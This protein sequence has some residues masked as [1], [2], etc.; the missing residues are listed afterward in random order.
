MQFHV[1]NHQLA[2]HMK[3]TIEQQQNG[4]LQTGVSTNRRFSLRNGILLVAGAIGL[5]AAGSGQAQPVF[6][7]P[8]YEPF[9]SDAAPYSFNSAYNN[10][11][12]INNEELG[13][14]ATDGSANGSGYVWTF[15][16][17]IS[18]SCSRILIT[19]GVSG[20]EYPGL[21][22]V[23]ATYQ[24]GLLSMYI[25]DTGSTKDRAV[26]L[27]IPTNN[28]NAPFPIYASCL[29][30]IQ[31]NKYTSSSPFAFF[32]LSAN[33]APNTSV[34]HNGA[35]AYVSY[36]GVN[37]NF[38]LQISKNSTTADTHLTSA[39]TTSN[40]YLLVLRYNY[41]AG[42]N[43][44]DSVDLWVDPIALG[45][46]VTV[47][48][49]TISTTNN[50]NLATNFFGAV[51][52]FEA[53]NPCIVY[54]DEIRVAT[55]WGGVTPTNA[56]PGNIY[57][58]TGG[59]AGCGSTSFDVGLSGSDT[60]VTYWLYTNGVPTGISANGTTGQTIDFGPQTTTALYTVAGSNNT[61]FNQGWMNGSASV[62]VLAAPSITTQPAPLA[63][64]RLFP[65]AAAR[66]T[67]GIK[68]R[69]L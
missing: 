18:S 68:A 60:G 6:P 22:N 15:A 30:S 27:S 47:P 38:Q 67:S 29:F 3:N 43:S 64:S 7:L 33:N 51:A 1:S 25:K 14:N 39:L 21:V 28:R 57:T 17:G 46:N 45:S 16:N 50:A 26:Q 42:T 58:V 31:T 62:S 32:G 23:D 65:A 8:F 54:I 11:G 2:N 61:T 52:I 55:N 44:N 63:F 36:N 13:Q 40:T 56:W 4:C 48:T 37:Q 69:R 49:P 9:P 59:G 34:S 66:C 10:V 35:T 20:L 53:A 12:Y 41:T 5:L 19:N 24:T